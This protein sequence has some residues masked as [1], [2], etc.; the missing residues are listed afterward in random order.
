MEEFVFFFHK[1]AFYYTDTHLDTVLLSA[2]CSVYSALLTPQKG[3][4]KRKS[5][6]HTPARRGQAC[7]YLVGF[8]YHVGFPYPC[9]L[10]YGLILSIRHWSVC[11][12]LHSFVEHKK[13]A[14]RVAQHCIF[15]RV[16]FLTNDQ[17]MLSWHVSS[18]HFWLR[19]RILDPIADSETL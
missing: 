2:L 6:M 19:R 3:K 1:I 4:R 5:K 14:N 9:A 13:A 16:H 15:H 10:T 11:M 12:Q 8:P 7:L 18:R 17:E